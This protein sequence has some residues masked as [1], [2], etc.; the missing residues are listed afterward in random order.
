MTT[1][2]KE[3]SPEEVYDVFLNLRN[4]CRSMD[5]CKNCRYSPDGKVCSFYQFNGFPE[6]WNLCELRG[7]P[8]EA[9]KAFKEE[10]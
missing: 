2:I 7:E 8:K 5:D 9:T 10:K 4:Y 1:E 6:N 3:Y